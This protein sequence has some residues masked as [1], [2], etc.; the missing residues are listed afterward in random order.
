MGLSVFT[1]SGG[2]FINGAVCAGADRVGAVR[3]GAI[4]TTC[5]VGDGAVRDGS[6]RSAWNGISCANSSAK[7]GAQKHPKFASVTSSA[8]ASFGEVVFNS[9]V[10]SGSSKSSKI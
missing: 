7:T 1:T 6:D 5:S 2:S 4:G 8:D 9:F 3:D 10:Q